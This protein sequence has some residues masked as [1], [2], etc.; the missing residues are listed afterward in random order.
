MRP[1]ANSR[2]KLNRRGCERSERAR[3]TNLARLPGGSK[4][5]QATQ[6]SRPRHSP[7]YGVSPDGKTI[8]ARGTLRSATRAKSGSPEGFHQWPVISGAGTCPSFRRRPESS[9]GPTDD[10][11]GSLPAGF[12]HDSF[13]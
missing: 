13:V 11:T 5:A 6:L 12:M 8:A 1:W 7:E 4:S 9:E 10:R 3:Q 2:E